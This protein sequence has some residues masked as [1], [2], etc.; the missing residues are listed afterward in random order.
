M[1]YKWEEHYSSNDVNHKTIQKGM[2]MGAGNEPQE[3]RRRAAMG[4]MK[5]IVSLDK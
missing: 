4:R 3:R 5:V 2:P 1:L